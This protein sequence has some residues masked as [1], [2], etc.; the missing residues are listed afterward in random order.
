MKYPTEPRWLV[1]TLSSS[2]EWLPFVVIV[3]AGADRA[4]FHLAR[5]GRRLGKA[6][7][8]ARLCNSYPSVAEEVTAWAEAE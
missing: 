4:H 6:S 7:D 5:N 8:L 3:L 1:E 2:S